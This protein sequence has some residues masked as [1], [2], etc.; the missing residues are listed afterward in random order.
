MSYI[1]IELKQV[2][3]IKT[4]SIDL[5]ADAETERCAHYKPT[6]REKVI[7]KEGNCSQMIPKED[8]EFLNGNLRLVLLHRVSQKLSYP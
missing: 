8:Y 4:E 7:Q 2:A 5:A 1:S 3:Y 6:K